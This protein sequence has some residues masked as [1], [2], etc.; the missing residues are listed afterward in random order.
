MATLCKWGEYLHAP[1]ILLQSL[2]LHS[3]FRS[4]CAIVADCVAVADENPA[5]ATSAFFPFAF[6]LHMMEELNILFAFDVVVSEVVVVVGCHITKLLI[7][8]LER[9][10]SESQRSKQNV[11]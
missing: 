3:S 9:V 2:E 4:V 10:Q 7:Q 11:Q 8:F 5:L 6:F 1:S